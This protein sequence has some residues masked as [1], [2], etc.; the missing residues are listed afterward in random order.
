MGSDL[1]QQEKRI[2]DLER[3]LRVQTDR[4]RNALAKC[5]ALQRENAQLAN[6]YV[7]SYRL[8]QSLVPT[9]V[10]DVIQEIVINLVGSEEFAVYEL[11]SRDDV[12]ALLGSF[13][14]DPEAVHT[15]LSALPAPA[16]EAIEKNQVVTFSAAR[17]GVLACVPL[18]RGDRVTGAIVIYS[19]LEHKPGLE[20]LDHELFELLATHAAPA[21]HCSRLNARE[22]A[23]SAVGQIDHSVS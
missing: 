15:E 13:G 20:R 12:L 2:A 4:A 7:S 21:L 3:E 8:Y 5:D 11:A 23:L 22:A 17:D 6:L 14:L 18:R 9:D 10:V 1:E 19:L 16:R